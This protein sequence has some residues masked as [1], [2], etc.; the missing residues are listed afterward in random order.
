MLPA[1]TES[2]SVTRSHKFT[3]VCGQKSAGFPPVCWRNIQHLAS[4]HAVIRVLQAVRARHAHS[5]PI[6]SEF[7]TAM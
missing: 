6:G 7:C 3:A 4:G 1:E 2:I 5:L